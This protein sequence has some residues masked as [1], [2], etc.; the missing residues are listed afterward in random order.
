MNKNVDSAKKID[1]SKILGKYGVYIALQMDDRL[2]VFLM[3]TNI[4]DVLPGDRF[5]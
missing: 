5:R 3:L 1:I 4:W 2:Q